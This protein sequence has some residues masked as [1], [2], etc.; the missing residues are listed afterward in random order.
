M[1]ILKET[2]PYF[3][4]LK[5]N[6]YTSLVLG[7]NGGEEKNYYY[8]FSTKKVSCIVGIYYNLSEEEIFSTAGFGLISGGD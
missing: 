5:I 8:T 4:Y 2:I 1:G 7:L 3:Y 6:D